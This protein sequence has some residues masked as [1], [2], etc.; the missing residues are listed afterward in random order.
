MVVYLWQCGQLQ[1]GHRA[2]VSR[3]GT[4]YV[5]LKPTGASMGIYILK[6][7]FVFTT[8]VVAKREITV[9]CLVTKAGILSTQILACIPVFVVSHSFSWR[10]AFFTVLYLKIWVEKWKTLVIHENSPINSWCCTV[11]SLSPVEIRQLVILTS[12]SAIWLSQQGSEWFGEVNTG[13]KQAACFRCYGIIWV[14]G[15]W[16]WIGEQRYKFPY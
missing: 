7:S 1:L 6:S 13:A 9:C 11:F 10:T 16:N 3:L 12:N 14:L 2:F 5:S 15:S 4:T 8:A